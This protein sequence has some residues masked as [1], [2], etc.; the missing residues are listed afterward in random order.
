MF[1]LGADYRFT[2][3]GSLV[4]I[5]QGLVPIGTVS[6]DTGFVPKKKIRD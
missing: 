4:G 3:V 6:M 5:A 1:N 2:P